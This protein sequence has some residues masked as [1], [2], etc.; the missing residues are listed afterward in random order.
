MQIISHLLRQDS[1]IDFS[2]DFIEN[3]TLKLISL[4]Y[5]LAK[6]EILDVQK[7]VRPNRMVTRVQIYIYFSILTLRDVPKFS[8]FNYL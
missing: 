3:K 8:F 6:K 1:F 2:Y 4:R 7:Q 5:S